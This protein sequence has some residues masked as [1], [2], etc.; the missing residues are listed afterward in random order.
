MTGISLAGVNCLV[1]GAGGFIG[2]HLCH[3]LVGEGASVHGF[4]RR[5]KLASTS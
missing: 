4:G 2:S 3:A 5:P 1:L